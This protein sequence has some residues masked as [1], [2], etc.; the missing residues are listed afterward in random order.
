MLLFAHAIVGRADLPIPVIWCAI[1]SAVVLVVSFLALAAGWSEPKLETVRQ[2]RLFGI[3]LTAEVLLGAVGVFVFA[4]VVYAGLAGV[5]SQSDNLAPKAVYVGFWVGVPCASLLFGDIFRL[6]SPWRA[7]GRATGWV[8]RK[9]APGDAL[10]EPLP[11]PERLGH[12]PAAAGFFAFIICELCWAAAKDPQPLA[13]LM[14]VY[15]AI[16]LVGMSLY[17]VE[18]WTRRADTFGVWFGMLASLAVFAR[19]DDGRVVLRPPGVGATRAHITNGTTALLVIAIGSTAFDGAREG[20]IFNTPIG[21][22]QETFAGWGT[23]LGFALELAMIVFLVVSIA[24]VSAIWAIVVLGMPRR[25]LRLSHLELS[26]RFVH[27]LIPIAA[28]YLVAHYFSSLAYEGQAVWA[29]M[30]DPLGH[31]SDIFGAASN[32][33]DYS[34][35]SATQ[36]WY[37]QVVALVIGHCTG[38]VLAHDRALQIYG[39]PR[40]AIASQIVMLVVMVMFTALGIWLLSEALNQ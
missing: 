39:S 18:P 28:A 38:L 35:V 8:A 26:R 32:G 12:W 9:V 5:D 36:I 3:P 21:D 2:R 37:I 15:L 29:L 33:I 11:Y 40:A 6:F 16:Q 1:A 13:I 34:I 17:G 20:A 19:G 25:S 24:A 4:V 27:T 10:P 30:S 23:S 14:L 22:L 31:G 7:I